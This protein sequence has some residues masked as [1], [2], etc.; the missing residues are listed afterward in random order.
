MI[1]RPPRSTLLPYTTL[2]RSE[3][4]RY[5]DKYGSDTDREPSAGS[6][7]DHH[8]TSE[9]D[10]D[11]GTD[12]DV[13]GGGSRKGSPELSVAEERRGQRR[14]PGGGRHDNRDERFPQRDSV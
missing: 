5:G 8:A 6:A 3:H 2:F 7:D 9:S 14:S 11:G 10:G 4:G 1:R 13:H 12:G